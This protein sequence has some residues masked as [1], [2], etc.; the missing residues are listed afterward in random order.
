VVVSS[1][2]GSFTS[3]S[4]ATPIRLAIIVTTRHLAPA[5]AGGLTLP[6][7]IV[8][9]T[10]AARMP[11]SVVSPPY[12]P[13][14][15]PASRR[16]SFLRAGITQLLNRIPNVTHHERDG[17]P[18]A[19]PKPTETPLEMSRVPRLVVMM[20]TVFLKSTTLPCAQRASHVA[21]SPVLCPKTGI[22]A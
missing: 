6:I 8:V 2:Q 4:T 11:V 16:L 19:V 7:L 21:S 14:N 1:P 15:T 10:L 3:C 9:S 20:M 5:R 13:A 18:Y 17:R 12:A 22:R